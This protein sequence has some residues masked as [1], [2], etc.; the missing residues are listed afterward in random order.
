MS[1]LKI[2]LSA[3][4]LP[5]IVPSSAA[6]PAAPGAGVERDQMECFCLQATT[7]T[8]VGSLQYYVMQLKG[9]L[10]ACDKMVFKPGPGFVPG[11]LLPCAKLKQCHTYA[12]RCAKRNMTARKKIAEL[13]AAAGR[14]V[15]ADGSPADRD[16]GCLL[17]NDSVLEMYRREKAGSEKAIK[18]L[19]EVCFDTTSRLENY[20]FEETAGPVKLPLAS[21]KSQAPGTAAQPVTLDVGSA[22]ISGGPK[23]A[24][25]MIRVPDGDYGPDSPEWAEALAS[26]KAWCGGGKDR[27]F[28]RL[29][30]ALE[31]PWRKGDCSGR[32]HLPAG[33]KEGWI[34]PSTCGGVPYAVLTRTAGGWAVRNAGHD[35]PG[36]LSR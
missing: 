11:S 27:C 26:V 12:G 29:T 15:R 32:L 14:C 9:V 18:L 33:G 1:I 25:G 24:D 31:T 23:A 28:K 5:F 8:T 7:G 3:W 4:F 20:K 35:Q 36:T 34:R 17:P 13:E 10:P 21:P 2:F 30:G 16:E 19:W 6:E 22:V